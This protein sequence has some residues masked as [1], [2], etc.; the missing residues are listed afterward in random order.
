[1]E[2]YGDLNETKTHKNNN[3]TII[4]VVMSIVMSMVLLPILTQ[5]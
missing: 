3:D 2:K 1:M 4:V 5:K